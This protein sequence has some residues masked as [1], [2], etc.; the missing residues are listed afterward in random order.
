MQK[1]NDR[2]KEA[3]ISFASSNTVVVDEKKRLEKT[4]GWESLRSSAGA[5]SKLIHVKPLKKQFS[6]LDS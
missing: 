4:P 1:N 6:N 3:W 5:E 2:K